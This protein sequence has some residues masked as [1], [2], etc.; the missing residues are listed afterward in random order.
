MKT[1]L[2]QSSE[3][4]WTLQAMHLACAM[5]HDNHSQVILLGL[6]YVP[7]PGCLGTEFW[8]TT[9]TQQDVYLFS[10]CGAI[11]EQYQVDFRFEFIQCVTTAGALVTAADD[12]FA[13][14][15][16]AC[17]SPSPV[18]FWQKY[19]IWNLKRQL[20]RVDC[21]LLA[22]NKPADSLSHFSIINVM[23]PSGQISK[24]LDYSH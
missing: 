24:K 23:H 20:L 19:Q 5:A 9:L 15:I 12:F 14:V 1:I 4:S 18:P 10:K 22:L 13:D 6:A 8:H 2:V 16:F 21:Q 3:Y 17:V 7:H 11:A